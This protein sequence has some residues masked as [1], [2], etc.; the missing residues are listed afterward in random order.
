MSSSQVEALLEIFPCYRLPQRGTHHPRLDV[1]FYD[2]KELCEPYKP[3]YES[4]CEARK[5]W[6]SYYEDDYR[7][8]SDE[9]LLE[10]CPR[11][12][13]KWLKR[14]VCVV[15]KYEGF[16]GLKIQRNI[17]YHCDRMFS[18]MASKQ[19]MF[20]VCEDCV[21]QALPYAMRLRELAELTL[22]INKL[23]KV[24]NEERRN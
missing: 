16:V 13:G 15:C 9:Y 1:Y 24:I 3:T 8:V 5:D 6:Q 17:N 20:L 7:D 21:P 14:G 22:F 23:K 10:S 12:L 2:A 19:G 18:G 4:F 11:P